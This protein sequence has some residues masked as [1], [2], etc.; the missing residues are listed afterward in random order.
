MTALVDLFNMA[1]SH[2]GVSR[3]ISSTTENSVEAQQCALHYNRVRRAVLASAPFSCSKRTARLALKAERGTGDWTDAEPAPNWLYAYAAPADMMRPYHLTTF[4]N[5]ELQLW[6]DNT[7]AILAN[8]K[9]AI[10]TY[11]TDQENIQRW[12]PL[13]LQAMSLALGSAVT[14]ALTGKTSTRTALAQAATVAVGEAR[15]VA[16]NA[17]R[18][19]QTRD[20]PWMEA[21]GLDISEQT[22]YVYPLNSLAASLV[23]GASA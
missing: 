15:R 8:A 22:H 23:V 9:D 10:F 19:P 3:Q 6:P 20:A 17:D 16:A 13:L 14:Q 1:L 12:E 4:E 21:R 7:Q 5:F 11:L 2:V 18:N